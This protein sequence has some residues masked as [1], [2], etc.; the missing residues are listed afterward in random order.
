MSARFQ[1]ER[2]LRHGLNSILALARGRLSRR[3]TGAFIIIIAILAAV[4][5]VVGSSITTQS[6]EARAESELQNDE[7]IVQLYFRQ[8]EDDLIF[9]NELLASSQMLTEELTVPSASRS[10]MIALINDLKHRG[11]EVRMYERE[12]PADQPSSSIIQKGFLGIRTLGLAAGV[13][14][15]GREAWLI[16]VAPIEREGGVERVLSIS[17]PLTPAYLK[18]ISGR[19][20]SD[21]TLLLPDQAISTLPASAVAPV[22]RQVRGWSGPAEKVEEP[23]VLSTVSAGQP[24]KARISPF[25]I[26]L[27]K[28]G[29]LILTIPM[30]DLLAAKRSIVSK[31]LLSTFVLLAG[32]SLLYL[33]LI[34]RIT[35]PLGQLSAATRDVAG[36][37]LDLQ[38][39]V[40][41]GDDEIG[42]LAASFNVMIQRLRESRDEIERWNQTLEKRVEERTHSLEAARSELK[43]TN[44]QLVEAL[45]EVQRAQD[46]M[47]RAEKLAALGQMA[48]AVAHEVRNPL[49]GMRGALQVLLREQAC[50]DRAP[51]VH[52]I[53]EQIDRL[54][55]TTSRLL[56]FARP[57][58]PRQIP[59]DLAELIDQTRLLVEEQANEK[60]VRIVMNVEPVG[61]LLSV[62][63]QLTLQA[64]LNIALNAVQ[65]MSRGGTLTITSKWHRD[66]R[67]L[68]VTFEDTGE[69]MSPEVLEKIFTPFF[70]TKHQGTGL[71]L[72]VAKDIIEQQGG[73][74]EVSSTPGVGTIFTVR[75]PTQESPAQDLR[76]PPDHHPAASEGKN[77][78][79]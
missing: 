77:E 7:A 59:S 13:S 27:R 17:F 32:S 4:V 45:A 53:I 22:I 76:W 72:Y 37:N 48:S 61:S 70:T 36:G 50:G 39:N 60:G 41:S 63:P 71:G 52:L 30:T 8:L 62:D 56:S 5:M 15:N 74:V 31:V 25:V 34:R 73:G 29:L 79:R 19:I 42:E 58:T 75:L 20:G 6:I 16:G 1:R 55:E 3:L 66:A 2:A 14:G 64:F 44:A 69:G 49:A 54:S 23:W 10:L 35:K 24:A 78:G 26:N 51:V 28:E 46:K 47:I 9:L 68:L 11:M 43:A 12:P 40:A 33:S 65:A 67:E 18:G 21:V 38:V 57:A